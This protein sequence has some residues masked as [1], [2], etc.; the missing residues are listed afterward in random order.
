MYLL[1][2]FILNS[3]HESKSEGRSVISNSLGPHGLYSPWNSPSPGQNTGVGSLSIL[4]GNFPTQGSN[5][6]L[7]YCRRI[8][9]QV[10][11]KGRPRMLEWVAYPVSVNLPDPGIEPGSPVL[12]VDSLPTE[13]SGKPNSVHP[14]PYITLPLFLLP[15][16]GH[17]V[18]WNESD[19][20]RQMFYDII[21][22][23]YLKNTT[24]K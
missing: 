9:Y 16:G 7:P 8:L 22:I 24:D 23:W 18:N 5:S 2:P 12:Q 21:Y 14:S 3:V 19:R 10:S 1:I 6:G 11:H 13:L 4:Q 17:Y 15:T 20:V